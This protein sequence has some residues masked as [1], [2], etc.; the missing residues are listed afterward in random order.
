[1]KYYDLRVIGREYRFRTDVP[2]K[3]LTKVRPTYK[4][5]EIRFYFFKTFGNNNSRKEY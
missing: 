2:S 5:F 4:G 3:N 1:M